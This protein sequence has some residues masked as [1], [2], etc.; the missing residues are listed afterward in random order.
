[1]DGRRAR[2]IGPV[3]DS[4][5]RLTPARRPPASAV[6]QL[7]VGWA[8]LLGVGWPL[9][10][11]AAIALEPAPVEPE[12]APPVLAELA[13]LAMLGGL[14]VTCIA[15]A[16]RQRSA[17]VAAVATGAIALGIVL[18]CPISGHHQ[19]GLWWIAE[20]GVLAAMTALSVAALGRRAVDSG[21]G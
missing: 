16:V 12:A 15:A 13:Y 5:P 21:T 17:A 8:A 20:L 14:M 19:Y 11:A 10:Y 4:V 7:K 2:L 9:A 6:D 18:A 1:M 3:R